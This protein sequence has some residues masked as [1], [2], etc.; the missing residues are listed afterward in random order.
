MLGYVLQALQGIFTIIIVVGA[1][2]I[3]NR[4]GWFHAESGAVISRLVTNVSLPCYLV[5]GLTR[6]FTAEELC[7]LAPDLLLPVLSILLAMFVSHIVARL[8]HVRKGR[9]GVF[10]TNFFI[11]NTVFIG[12]PV[13]LALFGD[14]SIPAV[15]LYYM[16]NTIFFWTFGVQNIL[17]DTTGSAEAF[18]S[19]T[20]LKKLFSP[21]LLGFLTALILIFAECTLPAF[22]RAGLSYIGN[23]T[24]PLSLLFIGIEISRIPLRTFRFERDIIWGL[25]GRFFIS[26]LC[27]M[28]LVPFVPATPLSIKIFV[29]QAA[30]PAMTQMAIV[31]KS[32][33]ADSQYAAALSMITI[34]FG[35]ITIPVYMTIVSAFY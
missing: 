22:L 3:L 34:L 10:T 25:I 31:A 11:A 28:T 32:Y 30:M 15:M 6:S 33:G 2:F 12:L 4:R 20:I 14:E 29:M 8:L 27:V 13:N 23:L 17:A 7:R 24:T 9:R 26:P 35:L 5:A 16:A 18:F 21:P 1:G 19:R